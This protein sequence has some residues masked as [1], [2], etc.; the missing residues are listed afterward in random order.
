MN[1]IKLLA[2]LGFWFWATIII[3]LILLVRRERIDRTER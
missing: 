1:L 3:G 2:R